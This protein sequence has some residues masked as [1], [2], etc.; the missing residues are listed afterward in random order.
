MGSFVFRT[1]EGDVAAT[2]PYMMRPTPRHAL[3]DAALDAVAALR[4]FGASQAAERAQA[5]A[6]P[7]AVPYERAPGFAT[8]YRGAPAF[9]ATGAPVPIDPVT[10]GARSLRALAE[11]VGFEVQTLT[12]HDSCT[13]EGVMRERRIG[14][15][16]FWKRGKTAGASWH[17]PWRYATVADDRPPGLNAVSRTGKQGYRPPG[18]GG[19]RTVILGTPWGLGLS[20]TDLTARIQA[21]GSAP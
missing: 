1:P 18:M 7:V 10:T 16:A 14:F 15:R 17:E 12:T 11:R 4:A 3:T 2:A 13:V 6:E 8:T 5:P 20:V 21:L 19:T 9:V